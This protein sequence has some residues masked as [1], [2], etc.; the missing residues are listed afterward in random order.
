M[1]GSGRWYDEVRVGDAFSRTLTITDTHLVLGR[2]ADRRLQPAPRRRRRSRAARASARASCTAMITSALMGAP[3][4][5]YFHGTAIALPRARGALHRAGARRRH[6]DDDVDGRRARHDKPKHGGGIVVLHGDVHATRT[7]SSS[8]RPTAKMLVARG[9]AR[10][11]RRPCAQADRSRRPRCVSARA[12]S[13]TSAGPAVDE[14]GVELHQRRAGVDLLARVRA[15]QDAADADDRQRAVE[16][17]RERAHDRG[18]R[19]RAAAGPTGR[20]PRRRAAA[21]RRASRAIVVLVAITPS[22]PCRDEQPRDALDRRVGSRSGAILTASG[23]YLP[24]RCASVVCSRLERARAAR[25]SA[26]SRLQ[27]AQALGVRRR[28]VDGDVARR[29]A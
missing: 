19:A 13:A 8:P 5:M 24:C 26:S 9:R 12:H 17:L 11:R 27:V 3:V 6:A 28:D 29:A 7:A 10:A 20:R 21:L 14:P 22:M 18:R 2:G 15:R 4:G 25:A 16:R 1:D 23:V